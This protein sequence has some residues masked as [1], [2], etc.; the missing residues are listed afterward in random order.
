MSIQ[1]TV[2]NNNREME[3]V[4]MD[5]R[6]VSDDIRRSHVWSERSGSLKITPKA[7]MGREP[8][9]GSL[10]PTYFDAKHESLPNN[11]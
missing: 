3:M 4:S 6:I 5:G 1:A 7:S 2:S 11:I 8:D 9:D 10:Y